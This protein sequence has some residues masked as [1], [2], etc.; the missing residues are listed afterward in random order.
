MK[1]DLCN[2]ISLRN[3]KIEAP[4]QL[5]HQDGS[6]E[7]GGV[8][9]ELYEEIREMGTETAAETAPPPRVAASI[10]VPQYEEVMP[11]GGGSK[12]NDS[13]QVTLCEAYGI[14]LGN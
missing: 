2:L 14:T 5:D 3:R 10:A 4:V 1:N 7:P 13:Y 9:A 12:S 11:V 6:L 8:G